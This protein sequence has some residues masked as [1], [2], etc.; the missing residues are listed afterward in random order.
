MINCIWASIYNVHTITQAHVGRGIVVLCRGE[1]VEIH[2]IIQSRVTAVKLNVHDVSCGLNHALI[3]TTN[4]EV[5]AVGSNLISQCG[6][7]EE[8][9]LLADPM[10]LNSRAKYVACGSTCS[11]VV[12]SDGALYGVGSNKNGELG[13]SRSET[14]QVLSLTKIPGIPD[15]IDG[16]S[17]G[18]GHSCVIKGGIMYACGVNSHGQLSFCTKEIWQEGFARV[19]LPFPVE[20]V[21]CG[22]WCTG[23]L[24]PAG[25]IYIAGDVPEFQEGP[26]PLVDVLAEQRRRIENEK[27]DP[28]PV[29]GMRKFTHG[30]VFIDFAVGGP[31][32]LVL[33]EGRRHV[34][35]VDLIHL[36][37]LD[38]WNTKTD[39]NSLSADGES[40]AFS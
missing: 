28:P 36:E 31:T 29:C 35:L 22:I 12:D 18:F 26:I 3:L 30:G 34:L 14:T 1:D 5:Y 2:M 15:T 11:F 13:F 37:V 33:L 38:E 17:S 6:V 19:D 27:S 40:W 24:T 16:V 4:D 8:I 25:E 7:F 32:M 39:V 21:S 23:V 20:K 10:P 9:R